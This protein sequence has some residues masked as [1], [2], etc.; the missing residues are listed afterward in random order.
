MIQGIHGWYSLFL[1]YG[2]HHILVGWA[3]HLRTWGGHSPDATHTQAT[4]RAMWKVGQSAGFKIVNYLV[5][6]GYVIALPREGNAPLAYA[7]SGR[8]RLIF[9]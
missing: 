3:A 2:L 8:S 9:G 5:G 4:L 1:E 6:E 7:L